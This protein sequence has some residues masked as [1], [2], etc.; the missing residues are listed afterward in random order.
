MNVYYYKYLINFFYKISN[1]NTDN[2][3]IRLKLIEFGMP[4]ELLSKLNNFQCVDEN[5]SKFIIYIGQIYSCK[6]FIKD[7]RLCNEKYVL[8]FLGENG[9]GKT[10][11]LFGLYK[12]F[13]NFCS[14]VVSSI[15]FYKF[16]WEVFNVYVKD[17]NINCIPFSHYH[18]FKDAY[19]GVLQQFALSD[20]SILL[21][22]TSGKNMCS[23]N[24]KAETENF[25]R[26]VRFKCDKLKLKCFFIYV[27]NTK[28]VINQSILDIMHLSDLLFLTH[29]TFNNFNVLWI[30]KK[31]GKIKIILG[32][33]CDILP[34]N[35]YF[36]N[37]KD[38]CHEFAKLF[39]SLIKKI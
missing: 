22:D 37:C 28:N 6:Q 30:I 2:S 18:N 3:D 7:I 4:S 39:V 35:V 5:C 12:Q 23:H 10:T 15:D 24:L 17:N 33:V 31:F 1:Y 16:S 26:K 14:V 9:A 29:I 11:S 36:F 34:K 20:H 25:I 32:Y 13:C 27:L 38:L 21:L 8:I 19:N